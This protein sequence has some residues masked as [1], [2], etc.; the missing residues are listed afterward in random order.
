MTGILVLN[1]GFDHKVDLLVRKFNTHLKKNG[2]TINYGELRYF[3]KPDF[4]VDEI[5]LEPIPVDEPPSS[6]LLT[7][8]ELLLQKTSP[9]YIS[10][11]SV[12]DK[13]DY[14]LD[15]NCEDI[16]F[17]FTQT[18]TSPMLTRP[19]STSKKSRGTDKLNIL[20]SIAEESS[21][22]EQDNESNQT[23]HIETD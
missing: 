12:S 14:I 3:E 1:R 8:E 18:S 17:N 4:D 2:R 10:S 21:V 5:E 11:K 19:V 9:V 13:S 6:L 20:S 15:E 7:E 22:R 23:K 16:I